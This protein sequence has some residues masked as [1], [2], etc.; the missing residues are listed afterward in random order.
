MQAPARAPLNATLGLNGTA[1]KRATIYVDHV[2]SSHEFDAV[3][4]WL[5]KWEGKV[6]VADYSTG[7]YEHLWDIEGPEEAIAE[8]PTEWLCDSK[9]S[10]PKLFET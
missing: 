7:G 3:R 6:R 2:D 4:A 8:L 1:V 9:W 10:N 5:K